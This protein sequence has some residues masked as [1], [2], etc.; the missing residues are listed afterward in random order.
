MAKHRIPLSSLSVSLAA[1]A[2]AG[3]SVEDG[4]LVVTVPDPAPEP[5]PELPPEPKPDPEPQPEPEPAPEPAPAPVEPTPKP[6]V[7]PGAMLRSDGLVEMTALCVQPTFQRH[8]W[9]ADEWRDLFLSTGVRYWR[10]SIGRQDDATEDARYLYEKGGVKAI[11]LMSHFGH[12]DPAPTFNEAECK[13]FFDQVLN[14]LGP[15]KVYA[16]EG[17]NESNKNAVNM[18]QVAGEAGRAQAFIHRTVKNDPRLQHVKVIGP[19]IYRRLSPAFHAFAGMGDMD[20]ANLH[21]YNAGHPPLAGEMDRGKITTLD[22]LLELAGDMAPGKPVAV[23]ETGWSNSDLLGPSAFHLDP[24]VVSAYSLRLMF[25]LWKRG[26]PLLAF[27]GLGDQETGSSDY[28][29]W[30]VEGEGHNAKLTPRPLAFDAPALLRY[31]A[32]PVAFDPKPLDVTL[33]GDL[34]DVDHVLSARS[35]G[36]YD[37]ALWQTVSLWDRGAAKVIEPMPRYVTVKLPEP[38]PISIFDPHRDVITH[39]G[40]QSELVVPATGKVQLVRIG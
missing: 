1:L 15:E 6:P 25:Q 31:M 14:K 13:A 21:S 40:P 20:W 18:E 37:L 29:W 39:Y 8:Y 22:H 26:C 7:E 9:G 3:L 33:S 11:L 30:A 10:G 27:F 28:G 5:V 24:H 19:S 35:D 23:T 16:M 2:E 36:R 17:W 4:D 34:T 38:M 12:S 32:D